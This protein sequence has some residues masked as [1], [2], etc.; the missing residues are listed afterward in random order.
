[1]LIW[2]RNTFVAGIVASLPLVV[3]VYALVLL[4]RFTDGLLGPLISSWLEYTIPGLGFVL[5]IL[6]LLMVGVLARNLV[7]QSLLRTGDRLM[8]R[9]PLVRS[10]Y[11]AL[12][13][14]TD[15]LARPD[16]AAFK[17]VVL[18]QY[19]RG[20]LYTVGFMTHDQF[21]YLVGAEPDALVSVF[22]PTTPNPTSGWLVFVPRE[23][24]VPLNMSV[25]EGAKLVISGGVISPRLR[26]GGEP[27]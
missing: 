11:A 16:Q 14:I 22:L 20:G 25:E 9:V 1:M 19:P 3:T 21:G 23:D 26:S 15:A 27:L 7:G 2:L 8:L 18:I 12:K 10:I 24:V 17:R 4:F 5:A 6:L 13:Q